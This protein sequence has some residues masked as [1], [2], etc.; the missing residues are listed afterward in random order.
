MASLLVQVTSLG[1]V[2]ELLLIAA[3]GGGDVIGAAMLAETLGLTPDDVLMATVA[4]ERL[5]IDPVPGPRSVNDFEG[6]RHDAQAEAFEILPTTRARPPFGSLLPQ[7]RRD[8][9]FPIYLL[10]PGDGVR[11][12]LHQLRALRRLLSSPGVVWL[13][14]VGGDVLANGA[15][16]GLRSPLCDAMTLAA[17]AQE[18]DTTQVLVAGPG[19]D[20]ELTQPEIQT[21]LR[22]AH[23]HLVTEVRP[24]SPS[25]QRVLEWHPTEASALLAASAQGIRGRVEIRDAGIPIELTTHSAEVWTM[26][27][28]NAL[29]TSLGQALSNTTS[30]EEAEA[31]L[32][33]K[34]GW[35]ELDHERRKAGKTRSDAS[36]ETQPQ[37]LTRELIDLP[38][39]HAFELAARNRGSQYTTF[40]RLAEQAQLSDHYTEL[41]A[42]LVSAHSERLRGPLWSLV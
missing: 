3:G 37:A 11:G 18:D 41:R 6:L 19:L 27:A 23:A 26:S 31:A 5:L 9:G 17:A 29:S 25:I 34:I 15:E 42:A 24:P 12:L 1:H 16:P 21:R 13:V 20:G 8:L 39:L 38:A 14:D 33:R 35:T 7:L 36:D 28:S 2:P 22:E 40:R 30:M 32:H 4:W 10:D